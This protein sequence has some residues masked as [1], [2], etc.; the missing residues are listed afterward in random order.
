MT[1]TPKA[2]TLSLQKVLGGNRINANDQFALS[3]TGTGAPAATT[4]TGSGSVVSSP[5]YS[6]VATPG[7]NYM[8]TEAKAS[9]TS[10]LTQYSQSVACTNTGPTVVT[11]FTTL[12]INVTPVNGDAINCTVTN[13][14]KAATLN[15]QV[16]LRGSNRIAASDQFTLSGTGTGAAAAVNTTGTGAAI[17]SPPYSFTAT[18]GSAYTLNVAMAAGSASALVPRKKAM[19]TVRALALAQYDLTV[20][21]SNTGPT[22][23]TGFT[24]VPISVTP[25]NGDAIVCTMAITPK[26]ATLSLQKVLGG[27]GR[28]ATTDQFTL[29]GT[30]AG[31]PA[32]VNTT[33]GGVAVTS[34]AYSVT[35]TAGSAYTL[36]ETMA[37]GS[38]SMLTQYSQA[39]SC[40]NTGPT[41]V[42][43]FTTLPINVTPVNGDAIVCTVTNTPKVIN[44]S[45]QI[46][47]GT[48]GRIAATDQFTLSGT[49][50]GTT[51]P[52]NTTG[53][54]AA[55][56]S[57]A[58]SFTAIPG[59]TYSLKVAMATGSTSLLAQY[60]QTVLC[61]NAGPTNVS[62]ITRLPINITPVNGDAISCMFVT[63]PIPQPVPTTNTLA[64][65]LL[66][67]LLMVSTGLMVRTRR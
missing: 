1:N 24:T 10:L 20:S 23:V 11:S 2:A 50:T 47:L 28:I 55:I 36:T 15:L 3:G 46:T 44:F 18:A 5:A 7:S 57:A 22:D 25:V 65:L 52:V 49:G 58:Y 61:T 40:T 6:I 63:T 14:P 60:V 39:V 9:G 51:A 64:L 67:L 29:S 45:L 41:V 37:S 13:T 62:G 38:A 30:G 59:N 43:N 27:S 19:A 21:C 26:A 4:T 32:A 56:T 31:S 8:M 66:A 42:T 33:G 16:S 17:T 53:T 48:N 12:P 54:G 35:A 34:G